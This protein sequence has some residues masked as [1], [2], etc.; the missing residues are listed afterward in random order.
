VLKNIEPLVH[1][2][3]FIH[4]EQIYSNLLQSSPHGNAHNYSGMHMNVP[5]TTPLKDAS[6]SSF[7]YVGKIKVRYFLNSGLSVE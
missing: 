6:Q 2:N 7:V 5:Y 4:I 1:K 3:T